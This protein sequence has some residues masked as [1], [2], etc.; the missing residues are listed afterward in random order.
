MT[1]EKDG[2]IV[3]NLDDEIVR[4][5]TLCHQNNLLWPPPPI[6]V[7]AAP[8]TGAAGA[9]GAVAGAGAETDGA[10]SQPAKKSHT[11]RNFLYFLAAVLG[12]ALIAV[13]PTGMLQ[14]YV[15]LML[16]IV[17]GFYVITNVTH[18]LHTPLMSET[19]AISGIILVGAILSLAQSS[20]VVVT[21]LA[22]LA[23]VIASINIFGGFAVTHK[24]LKMFQK[25]D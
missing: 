11:L 9:A 5:I 15:V 20:S 18:A 17:A 2:K 1:P 23:I 19:N 21:V 12:L 3:F 24:M 22:C 16:A 10:A 4:G 7:S 13:S 14:Y 8:K 6:S 25:E